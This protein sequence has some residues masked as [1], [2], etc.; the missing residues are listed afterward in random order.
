MIKDG[1]QSKD[2]DI[3]DK[4]EKY[5]EVQQN[6]SVNGDLTKHGCRLFIQTS[7]RHSMFSRV[8]EARQGDWSQQK[9]R[10]TYWPGIDQDIEKFKRGCK[11]P[12]D[13]LASL[14][15]ELMMPMMRPSSPGGTDMTK[16]GLTQFCHLKAHDLKHMDV[17]SHVAIIRN[18]E[19]KLQDIQG[20]VSV[21]RPCRRSRVGRLKRQMLNGNQRFIPKQGGQQDRVQ[22]ELMPP[23]E[24]PPQPR[25]NESNE[26]H[27]A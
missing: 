15:S 16:G 4:I 10:L 2:R 20:I 14:T 11:H 3:L 24:P 21:M 26:D 12:Q 6:L 25:K 7:L 18:M 22:Q 9:A 19:M 5:W 17:G 1:S 27:D 23:P 13:S 8:H